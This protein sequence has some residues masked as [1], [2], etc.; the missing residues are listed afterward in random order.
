MW[1]SLKTASWD[2]SLIADNSGDARVAKGVSARK[3]IELGK[4]VRSDSSSGQLAQHEASYLINRQHSAMIFTGADLYNSAFELL[5]ANI[6]PTTGRFY[7]AF[8]PGA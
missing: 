7:Q 1:N 3:Y 4:L 8:F 6:L 5:R 2:Y